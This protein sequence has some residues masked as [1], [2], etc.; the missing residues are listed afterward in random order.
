[1][2]GALYTHIIPEI[3]KKFKKLFFSKQIKNV[4]TNFYRKRFMTAADKTEN[5]FKAKKV[6]FFKKHPII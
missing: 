5:Y 1:V 3:I 2:S 6:C 4:T